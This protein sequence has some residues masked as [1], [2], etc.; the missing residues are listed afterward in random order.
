VRGYVTFA[1]VP[2]EIRISV[3][4]AESMGNYSRVFHVPPSGTTELRMMIE[5]QLE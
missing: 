3:Y 4:H 1:G 2:E 5:P